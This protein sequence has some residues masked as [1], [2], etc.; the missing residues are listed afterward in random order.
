MKTAATETG[1]PA[2]AFRR[3]WS[4][5]SVLGSSRKACRACAPPACRRAGGNR[6]AEP[7][8]HVPSSRRSTSKAA[9][10][11]SS[12]TQ[13]SPQTGFSGSRPRATRSTTRTVDAEAAGRVGDVA[14]SK[15]A[16]GEESSGAEIE[17]AES[18]AVRE[19]GCKI[20]RR[21]HRH[22]RSHPTLS[23]AGSQVN[24]R[25]IFPISRHLFG[26]R[27]PGC[28]HLRRGELPKASHS[29]ASSERA[30]CPL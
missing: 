12:T 11:A 7:D 10:A 25:A 27:A 8:D 22:K 30:P 24:Y 4:P 14:Q 28:P 16:A 20:R 21:E 17:I 6:S 9:G 2:R 23:P 3:R 1:H 13:P 29:F 15:V 18:G 5:L 26:Q 19:G